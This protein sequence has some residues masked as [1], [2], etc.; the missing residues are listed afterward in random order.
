VGFGV[1]VGVAVGVGVGVGVG[2]ATFSGDGP[3]GE[4]AMS[5]LAAALSAGLTVLE[6]AAPTLATLVL[7][8]GEPTADVDPAD[9][10]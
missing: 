5:A 8:S 9:D 3:A 2:A 4:L 6:L 7:V 10:G 1:G